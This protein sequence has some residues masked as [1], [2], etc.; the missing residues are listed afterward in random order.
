MRLFISLTIILVLSLILSAYV[1]NRTL[2][3]INSIRDEITSIKKDII[4]ENWPQ[5]DQ[6]VGKLHKGWNNIQDRWDFYIS[7][8]EIENIEMIIARLS[9]FVFSQDKASSLA[10]LAALDMQLSHIYR[11]E[12]FNLQNVF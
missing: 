1:T 7:H 10:E 9:S 2:V 5:V 12:M 8:Q 6:Q 4:E 11:K 3:E